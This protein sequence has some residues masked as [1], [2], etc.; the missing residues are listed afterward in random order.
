M[1]FYV[2]DD[3]W[4]AVAGLPR[5]QQDEAM[6]A[7]ARLAFTGEMTELSGSPRVAL[8][9]FR[10]RILLSVERSRNGS[11]GGSKTQANGQAK[12]KQTAEQTSSKTQANGQ[13]KRQAESNDL[14]K[15][16]SEREI[17]EEP[18][19]GGSKKTRF[20]A[21]TPVEAR[22]YAEAWMAETGRSLPFSAERFCD[23]YASK[24]WRVGSTPMKDWRAAVRG[25]IVR[26]E[27]K[28][29]RADDPRFA[30]YA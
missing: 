1:G 11:K 21:P 14:L 12:R 28:G 5:R 16:E 26:D 3:M 20:R 17:E 19:K 10:D 18:P 8:V 7:I 6:G 27:K 4:E 2:Q 23:F 30:A 29:A 13:A 24:G 9:A 15:S 22:E 25:W